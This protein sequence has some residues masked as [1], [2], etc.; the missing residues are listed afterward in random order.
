MTYMGFSFVRKTIK[1]LE[2]V[3]ENCFFFSS[4][5]PPQWYDFK[6]EKTIK[7]A[8]AGSELWET[9]VVLEVLPLPLNFLMLLQINHGFKCMITP[10]TFKRFETIVA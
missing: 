7:S 1:V 5:H 10:V 8:L 2:M 6:S 3:C 4:D 9:I